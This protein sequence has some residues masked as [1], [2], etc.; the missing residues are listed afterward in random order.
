MST[1]L[2]SKASAYVFCVAALVAPVG[3]SAGFIYDGS[4]SAPGLAKFTQTNWSSCWNWCGPGSAQST[5]TTPSGQTVD[6]NY[7]GFLRGRWDST[8]NLGSWERTWFDW[9]GH[10]T[11]ENKVTFSAPVTNP[12]MTIFHMGQFSGGG[13]VP[14]DDPSA[15]QFTQDFTILDSEDHIW[16]AAAGRLEGAGGSAVIQFTGTFTEISWFLGDKQRFAVET[17]LTL[18]HAL[19]GPPPSDVPEPDTLA[20]A[21]AAALAAA[22]A[23]RWVE[24][25]G[26]RVVIGGSVWP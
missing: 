15:Y 7:M 18:G 26:V 2:K 8:N 5:W 22:A 23:A 11:G 3:A 17:S 24:H 21:G 12:T 1:L 20:L 16:R 19:S 6:V 9:G 14:V 13:D 4:S 10:W 25:E